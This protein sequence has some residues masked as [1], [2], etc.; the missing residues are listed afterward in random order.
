LVQS[1]WCK[2]EKKEKRE[3]PAEYRKG[4]DALVLLSLGY[5]VVQY[6]STR[7]QSTISWGAQTIIGL[8]VGGRWLR[9]YTIWYIGPTWPAWQPTANRVHGQCLLSLN[10]SGRKANLSRDNNVR[11]R[12]LRIEIDQLTRMCSQR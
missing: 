6:E 1:K 10:L 3:N 12:S 2:T 11:I 8:I 7:W 5:I 4:G 9:V